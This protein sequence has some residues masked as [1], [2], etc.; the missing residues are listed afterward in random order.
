M[1]SFS[2]FSIVP[3]EIHNMILLKV[4]DRRALFK[5]GNRVCKKWNAM[6]E[7]VSFYKEMIR[8]DGMAPLLA[9]RFKDKNVTSIKMYRYIIYSHMFLTPDFILP[10]VMKSFHAKY[11]EKGEKKSLNNIVKNGTLL[12]RDP[13][14]YTGFG[15]S[16]NVIVITKLVWSMF[17]GRSVYVISEEGGS[18]EWMSLI[19]KETVKDVVVKGD[20]EYHFGLFMPINLHHNPIVDME[21]VDDTTDCVQ[22]AKSFDR[23][24]DIVIPTHI[25]DKY[26]R[27]HE[28]EKRDICATILLSYHAS[29]MGNSTKSL[30]IT[31]NK[32]LGNVE[33]VCAGLISVRKTPPFVHMYDPVPSIFGIKNEDCVDMNDYCCFTRIIPDNTTNAPVKEKG[34]NKRTLERDSLIE[35]MNKTFKK[36]NG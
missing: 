10:Y 21:L 8:Q 17:R 33:W 11:E 36:S 35:I 25:T 24:K 7:C 4:N 30:I 19:L 27:E 5:Y 1:D 3:D 12:L 22:L 14:N 28:G 31:V 13:S 23:N 32:N 9:K 15:L 6:I 16:R 34:S 26:T 2:P 29:G 18:G 20:M